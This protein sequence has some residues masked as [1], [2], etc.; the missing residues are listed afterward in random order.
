MTHE[1]VVELRIL[2]AKARAGALTPEERE[3]WL[4]ARALLEKALNQAQLLLAPRAAQ[5]RRSFRVVCALEAEVVLGGERF[6][7]HTTNFS[8]GGFSTL[9]EREPPRG[10]L[11]P[12]SLWFPGVVEP[13]NGQVRCC[14]ARRAAERWRASFEFVE[15]SML[16]RE[17]LE[18]EVV[19]LELEM[20]WPAGRLAP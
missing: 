11:I 5:A 9:I 18:L 6:R 12:F 4:E 7:I 15:L 2:Q 16:T 14:G 20:L 13:I 8:T 1:Q 10:E 19:D 17:Q 3:R